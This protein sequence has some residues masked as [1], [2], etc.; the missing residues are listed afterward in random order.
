[1]TGFSAE[2]SP[3]HGPYHEFN[4]RSNVIISERNLAD[5]DDAC[6]SLHLA[7]ERKKKKKKKKKKT[8]HGAKALGV[9]IGGAGRGR[10]L[11]LH[12][13]DQAEMGLGLDREGRQD[14]NGKKLGR[15]GSV[16]A[17]RRCCGRE[18]WRR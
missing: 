18:K 14:E 6:G 3:P 17:F 16:S 1:M 13:G 4:H 9:V 15:H 2:A 10:R 7:T 8:Y 12:R 11:A 5:G